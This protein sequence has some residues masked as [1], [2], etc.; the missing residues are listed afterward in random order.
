MVFSLV[1]MFMILPI[2]VKSNMIHVHQ[3]IITH[4]E[5]EPVVDQ[6]SVLDE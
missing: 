5:D 6:A 4:K 3:N 1:P 2:S